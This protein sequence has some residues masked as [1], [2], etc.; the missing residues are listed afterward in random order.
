MGALEIMENDT[1]RSMTAR[2]KTQKSTIYHFS[3]EVFRRL[4]MKYCEN[5][6]RKKQAKLFKFIEK[7]EVEMMVKSKS[8]SEGFSKSKELT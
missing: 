2:C 5:I 8:I 1:M 7:K 3:E 4:I 6:I